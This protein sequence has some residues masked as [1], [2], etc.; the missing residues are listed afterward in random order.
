MGIIK[1][2]NHMENLKEQ[3]KEKLLS[4][5]RDGM[6]NVIKQYYFVDQVMECLLQQI[7]LE[8]L[9]QQQYTMKKEQN[10]LNLMMI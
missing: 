5:K 3:F 10:L 8:E 9:E 2:E 7:N 6:E 4:T 1:K